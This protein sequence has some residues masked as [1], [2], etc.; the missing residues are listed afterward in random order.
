M[1]WIK[2]VCVH[3]SVYRLLVGQRSVAISCST[4]WL[5]AQPASAYLD[6]AHVTPTLKSQTN[7]GV[8]C[9]SGCKT[10]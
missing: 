2:C 10:L 6:F 4:E 8:V 5:S 9:L 1:Q 3:V 7:I